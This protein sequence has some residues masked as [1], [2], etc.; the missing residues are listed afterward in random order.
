MALTAHSGTAAIDLNNSAAYRQDISEVVL[1][2]LTPQNNFSGMF[3][4]GAE[5]A[6]PQLWWNED[7]LNQYKVTGDTAASL[8]STAT[9]INF[10][11][12]DAAVL[13]NGYVLMLDSQVGDTSQESMQVVAVNGTAITVTRA[14]SGTAV[15]YPQN[16]VF[17]I[18]NAPINPNSDLG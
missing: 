18:I 2:S 6:G 5:F 1:V 14:F 15:S 8:A 7:A 17:R 9:T 16:S 13:K 3:Q 12:S 4:I 10:A 11:Q